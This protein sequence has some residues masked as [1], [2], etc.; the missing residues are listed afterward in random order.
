MRPARQEEQLDAAL[1]LLVACALINNMQTINPRPMKNAQQKRGLVPVGLKNV[2]GC[3]PLSSAMAI[4]WRWQTQLQ[5]QPQLTI[6]DQA[7]FRRTLANF[8]NVSPERSQFLWNAL[9]NT[10]PLEAVWDSDAVLTHLVGQFFPELN[11]QNAAGEIEA[12]LPIRFGAH[13]PVPGGLAVTGAHVCEELG[14]I[15]APALGPT[16][17]GWMRVCV[18]TFGDNKTTLNLLCSDGVA[19]GDAKFTVLAVI[20]RRGDGTKAGH[21]VAHSRRI[22]TGWIT[23]DDVVGFPVPNGVDFNL[24]IQCAAVLV[25]RCNAPPAAVRRE[26][27]DDG[28]A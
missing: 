24:P 21:Y 20:E 22:P 12:A 16:G 19:F 3:C 18:G 4:L 5:P 15:G 6:D 2:D 23:L 17:L 25:Q 10:S 1:C 11:W 27:D 8:L 26:R 9:R 14:L 28:P 13:V 7:I